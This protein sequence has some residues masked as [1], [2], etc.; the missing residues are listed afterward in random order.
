MNAT[1][2]YEPTREITKA[3]TIAGGWLFGWTGVLLILALM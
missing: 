1:E 2:K 3:L